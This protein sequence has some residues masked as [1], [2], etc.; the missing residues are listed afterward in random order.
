[1][2]EKLLIIDKAQILNI[3]QFHL[4]KYD[5]LLLCLMELYSKLGLGLKV[6]QN[7]QFVIE[8]STEGK[9][10]CL[11]NFSSLPKILYSSQLI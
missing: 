4:L 5:N 2:N 10:D 9:H 3:S 8:L 1:M 7:K 11:V 6:A